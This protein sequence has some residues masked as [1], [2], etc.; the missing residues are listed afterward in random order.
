MEGAP[1]LFF[2]K[3]SLWL[4]QQ[5][6][7]F[8]YISLTS[9]DINWAVDKGSATQGHHQPCNKSKKLLN[10][11]WYGMN[12]RDAT[13][14]WVFRLMKNQTA[15]HR[16]SYFASSSMTADAGLRLL[17]RFKKRYNI[18]KGIQYSDVAAL[19]PSS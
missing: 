19:I 2:T 13:A 14:N 12:V 15:R 18:R 4:G 16:R 17:G 7:C 3:L 9:L 5:S 8:S 1:P 6:M 10:M 11:V